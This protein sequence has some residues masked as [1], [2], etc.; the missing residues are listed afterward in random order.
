MRRTLNKQQM[1]CSA[2]YYQRITVGKTAQSGR[3]AGR[4]KVKKKDPFL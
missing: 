4:I 1:K 3:K 2:N